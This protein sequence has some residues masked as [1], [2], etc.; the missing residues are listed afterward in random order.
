LF[1]NTY[2]EVD[3][4]KIP[5]GELKQFPDVVPGQGFTLGRDEPAFDHCLVM[6]TEAAQ[7]PLDT[8]EGPMTKLCSF[9]HPS[10]KI[11]FEISSTEPAFQFYTG[12]FVDVKASEHTPAVGPRSGFCVE[13]SRYINAVNMDNCR[14]M[15]VLKKGQVWVSGS[16]HCGSIIEGSNVSFTLH[17]CADLNATCREAEH[18]IEPGLSDER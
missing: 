16:R 8:R 14:G 11:Y 15:V 5:T 2:Q 4:N 6:N 3:D 1:T 7:I 12:Q 13:A 18:L 17:A 10:T 9:Y